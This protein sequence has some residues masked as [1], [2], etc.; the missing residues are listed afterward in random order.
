MYL[1]QKKEKYFDVKCFEHVWKNNLKNTKFK[2]KRFHDLQHTFATLLLTNGA[3]L[4]KVKESLG[5]NSIKTTQIYL[6]VLS[7]TKTE[8][9]K[10]IDYLLN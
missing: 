10:K 6:E 3:N 8:I 7:K 4:I 2:D 9:I 1:A 5:H